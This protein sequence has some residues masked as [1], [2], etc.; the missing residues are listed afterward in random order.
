MSLGTSGIV[1]LVGV[2]SA[3]RRVLRR[4]LAAWE[5]LLLLI[6]ELSRLLLHHVLLRWRHMRWLLLLISTRLLALRRW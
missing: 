5:R 2:Y 6:A 3:G 1:V 4:H